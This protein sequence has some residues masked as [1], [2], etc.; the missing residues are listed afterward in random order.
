M[1]EIAC[2]YFVQNEP[3]DTESAYSNLFMLSRKCGPDEQV[4]FKDVVAEFP[5]NGAD[6]ACYH[7][8]F[9]TFLPEAPESPIWVDILN[10]EAFV[11]LMKPGVI[12]IKAL[13]LPPGL[14]QKLKQSKPVSASS[15]LST[16]KPVK[17]E[18][19]KNTDSDEEFDLGS[20]GNTPNKEEKKEPTATEVSSVKSEMLDFDFGISPGS[21]Q[22]DIAPVLQPSA[23]KEPVKAQSIAPKGE[24]RD[25][26]TSLK[27]PQAVPARPSSAAQAET[28]PKAKDIVHERVQAAVSF[29]FKSRLKTSASN[30]SRRTKTRKSA[31]KPTNCTR[32]RSK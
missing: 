22:P 31:T 25:S 19:A 16:P 4:R 21:K 12:C 23:Y 5:L 7:L 27:P 18:I 10:E 30:G 17:K 14:K 26:N 6:G 11:P 3:C 28:A 32:R 8:R 2:K 15:D 20:C 9:Q 13:R 1:T 24:V 29:I